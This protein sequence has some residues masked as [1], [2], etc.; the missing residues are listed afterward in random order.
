MFRSAALCALLL[1]LLMGCGASRPSP[2]SDDHLACDLQRFVVSDVFG[3]L[4]AHQGAQAQR[5]ETPKEFNVLALSA[6]GELGV[7]GAGFLRGWREAGAAAHPVPLSR[8][9]VVTAVSAGALLA[10]HLF[11][12][13]EPFLHEV[14]PQIGQDDLFG[15]RY[16]SLL[17]S[18]AFLDDA[19]KDRNQRETVLTSRV[20]D[21]VAKQPPGRFLYVGVTDLD[22]GRFLQ[23]DMTRLSR[24][25]EPVALRDRC[26]RAVI[27]ASTAIP[28]LMSPKF[29]DNMMLSD[30]AVRQHVFLPV[31]PPQTMRPD[32]QRRLL[33]IVHSE[34]LSAEPTG[35]GAVQGQTCNGWLPIALR[36][37]N[38]SASQGLQDSLRAVEQLARQPVAGSPY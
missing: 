32:V 12:G 17:W 7:Y 25:I 34:L 36:T 35:C 13:D 15:K 10:T 31:A 8:V 18:N 2:D 19:G 5:A 27:G 6:G 33:V 3:G 21:A 9:H 26:Y 4:Q 29:V 20:I 11:I 16:F 14:L 23:I 24:E 37:A 1:V 30:G 28:V 38:L 22:S